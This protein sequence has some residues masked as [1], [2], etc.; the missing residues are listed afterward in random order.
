RIETIETEGDLDAY[1]S[2]VSAGDIITDVT[3]LLFTP[4]PDQNGPAY[5]TF[6]FKVRDSS[7]AFSANDYTMT[8]N[9]TA[10]NDDPA[11][12]NDSITTPE[13]QNKSFDESDFTFDDLDGHT[14]NGIR[15]ETLETEGDLEENGSD[16][17]AGDI[18]EDVTTLLFKPAANANGTPYATFTFKVRD[19]SGAFSAN[20]YTM[21]INVTA[22]NDAPTGGDD[23]VTTNEDAAYTYRESD[24]TFD[25]V[26]G[27]TFNGIRIESLETAGDLEENGSDVS[28]GEV[29]EDVTTL[30]FTPAANAN[31]TPYATFAFK[32][33]DSSGAFSANDYTMTINVTARNDDPAGGNDSITATEDMTFTFGVNDFTFDDVDGHTFNGI[34]IE[35]LETEGDLDAYGADLSVTDIITDVTQLVFTPEADQNGADYAT[36]TFKVRDSSGELSAD[37]YTMTIHVTPRND[38]PTGGDDTV[39][40]NED[41]AYTYRESDFTF[42]DVDG[43]TFNGIRIESVETAGNLEAYGADVSV[44][45]IVTDVTQLVF[46]PQP[47]Q[48]GA[49]YATFTFNVR[50]SSGALSLDNYTM[51]I[52]VTAKN[53]DPTG[54]NDSIT[55]TEDMTFTFG[56]NHFTFADLDGHTFNGIR[57][58][59]IETEG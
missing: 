24:F 46:T 22:R 44:T 58:E 36:F 14:F 59:T 15:I 39:T 19:S 35:T 29:I 55:A 33:R 53:D 5:A 47:N 8:I 32:V 38:N 7:G 13:D 37:D 54:G 16:V 28:A 18:I 52:N 42:D 23:A 27:H 31:G 50:D 43:H 4:E 51:T 26:D 1:G 10:V 57:I 41:A 6:A 11:G 30:L 45:N 40:T 25:D 48:N 34:R 49:A 21:T 20:D 3:Q 9:V 17:S 2:D 12:G 56:V